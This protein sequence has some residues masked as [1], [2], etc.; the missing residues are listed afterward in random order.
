MNLMRAGGAQLGIKKDADGVLRLYECFVRVLISVLQVF[1]SVL[2]L[3]KFRGW[4]LR[5]LRVSVGFQ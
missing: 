2:R 3:P 4:R 1:F 5:V